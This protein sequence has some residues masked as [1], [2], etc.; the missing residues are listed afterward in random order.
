MECEEKKRATPKV[1]PRARVMKFSEIM[2]G[3]YAIKLWKRFWK[4]AGEGGG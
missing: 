2:E 1:K 3:N 4:G